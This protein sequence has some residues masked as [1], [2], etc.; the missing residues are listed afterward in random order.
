LQ[1]PSKD[2]ASAHHN[3]RFA[4]AEDD[5]LTGIFNH[6][7]AATA[8]FGGKSFSPNDTFNIADLASYDSA[9]GRRL[10]NEELAQPAFRLD[11]GGQIVHAPLLPKL[12]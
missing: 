3:D 8:Q 5:E 2:F 7:E 4:F 12:D 11:G 9:L 10:R 6:S 1:N